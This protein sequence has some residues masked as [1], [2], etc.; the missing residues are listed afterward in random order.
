MMR[1]AGFEPAQCFINCKNKLISMKIN[2]LKPIMNEVNIKGKIAELKEAREVMTKFGTATTLTEATLED[3][4]GTIKLVLWGNQA[5]G[6]EEGSE[7]EIAGG[8]TKEFR[9]ELQLG[10]GKRG[11]IK[12]V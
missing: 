8:F 2:E 5:E 11:S 7:V 10:I 1:R 3:D 4:S 9:E 6:I 12:V